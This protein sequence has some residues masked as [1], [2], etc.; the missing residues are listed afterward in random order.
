MAG[1]E[2]VL[3]DTKDKKK[4][5]VSVPTMLTKQQIEEK[6]KEKEEQR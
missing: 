4:I 6:I 2:Q 1:G 5:K 3:T